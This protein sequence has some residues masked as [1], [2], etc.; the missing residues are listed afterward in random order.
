MD[1]VAGAF[2]ELVAD[3]VSGLEIVGRADLADQV[4]SVLISRVTFDNSV[5][6]AYIYVK[7]SRTLNAV[8][9]NVIG[10]RHGET[11][12]LEGQY[13]AVLDTDNFG[14]LAGI[15]ILAPGNLKTELR[16]RASVYPNGA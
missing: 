13:W 8:E 1:T 5:D 4:R 12:P 10:V 11:I 9:Q 3:L 16:S 6:A 15:E 7:P 14:R 2:P